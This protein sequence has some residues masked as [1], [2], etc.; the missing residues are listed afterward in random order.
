[1]AIDQDYSSWILSPSPKNYT[2]TLCFYAQFRDTDGKL[3]MTYWEVL[4]MKLIFIVVFEHFVFA[5]A[6]LVD[7]LLP[8]MPKHLQIKLKRQKYLCRQKRWS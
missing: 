3:T 8:D 1:M 6:K 7:F 2:G 4:A 5:F